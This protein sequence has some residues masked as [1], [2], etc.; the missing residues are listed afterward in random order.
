MLI[1][2]ILIKRKVFEAIIQKLIEKLRNRCRTF[3][4]RT[5]KAF[6]IEKTAI[7]KL[8]PFLTNTSILC[9]LKKPQKTKSFLVLSGGITWEHRP[10]MG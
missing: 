10:E 9:L 7:I 6:N 1:D 3:K 2:F 8:N 5:E 4:N